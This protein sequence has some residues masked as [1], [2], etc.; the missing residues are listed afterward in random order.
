MAG[1]RRDYG[2]V[3]ERQGFKGE[4]RVTV[5]TICKPGDRMTQDRDRNQGKAGGHP[6]PA[7]GPG[8]RNNPTEN[9]PEPLPEIP[10]Q[11]DLST[12]D[13]ETLERQYWYMYCIARALSGTCSDLGSVI[14]G[15]TGTPG[16]ENL[17]KNPLS[18]K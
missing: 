10:P 11:P 7:Q 6:P 15:L 5:Y 1:N 13:R 16:S 3:V 14:R 18:P 9:I 12:W 8:G 4:K 2:T 17:Q